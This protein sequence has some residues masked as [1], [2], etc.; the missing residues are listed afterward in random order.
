MG[1]Y[2]TTIPLI[3]FRVGITRVTVFLATFLLLWAFLGL[4]DSFLEFQKAFHELCEGIKMVF[5][6]I[7]MAFLS[8]SYFLVETILKGSVLLVLMNSPVL[9]VVCAPPYFWHSV[10]LFSTFAFLGMQNLLE[11]VPFHLPFPVTFSVDSFM[12]F[13]LALELATTFLTFSR[14]P[15]SF[16]MLWGSE[17]CV[18]LYWSCQ[19]SGHMQRRRFASSAT[20]NDWKG[21]VAA[22]AWGLL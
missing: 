1:S 6:T 3:L 17:S 10:Q 22:V 15:N 16:L 13:S 18:R 21:L 11:L 5:L 20:S 14:M 19:D 9:W 8:N 4:F 2:S 12:A 7:A